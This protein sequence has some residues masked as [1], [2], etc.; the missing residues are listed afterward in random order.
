MRRALA[1]AT[2]GRGSVEPNPMVGCIIVKN[3]NVIG[4]GYHQKYGGPHAEPNALAACTESPAGATAYVTLEPCCHT[5]KQTAPC[6]PRLIAAGVERVVIGTLDP[7]PQVAG[8]GAAQLEAAG[9]RVDRLDL[10]EARQLI[11]PFIAR[12]T[13]GRPYV[14]LKWAQTADRKVAGPLG[15]R[16]QISNSQST[17]V[18]HELRS[19]CDAILVGSNTLLCDDPMLTARRVEPKRPLLRVVLDS[20]L[21][22]RPDCRLV[23]T[24]REG[25]VIVYT[26]PDAFAAASHR[27]ALESAGVEIRP[28]AEVGSHRVSLPAVLRDLG[29]RSVTHLLVEAGPTLARSFMADNGLW[30]RLWVITSPTSIND[31]S[32]PD[33]QAPPAQPVAQTMLGSDQLSEYLNPFS[34]VTFHEEPSADFLLA[35]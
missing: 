20:R 14:T 28:A 21:R 25:K 35:R 24:A 9:I 12:M 26:T 1:L 11:A 17:H 27:N 15:R 22:I 16:M 3:G 23:K 10:P 30:D 5:D 4:E 13:H 19:R 32:A 33:A 8:R 6:V 7:N 18:I 34:P 31:A 29:S 2:K